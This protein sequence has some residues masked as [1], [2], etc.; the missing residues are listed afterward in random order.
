MATSVTNLSPANA[1]DIILQYENLNRKREEI[2]K[3]KEA[4]TVFLN[5]QYKTLINDIDAY[6]Y[7][8]NSLN[9][10]SGG[11]SLPSFQE[12]LR[13]LII[14]H[15]F[16]NAADR[17]IQLYRDNSSQMAHDI[18][19][20]TKAASS[21]RW[22]FTSSREKE[23][24]QAAYIRLL[25]LSEYRQQVLMTHQ[26]IGKEVSS[27]KAYELFYSNQNVYASI[28]HEL[29]MLYPDIRTNP[30][31]RIIRLHQPIIEAAMASL[32]KSEE[33]HTELTNKI[34]SHATHLATRA[35]ID[36]LQKMD[37]DLLAKVKSGVRIKALR[38]AGYTTIASVLTASSYQ[39]ASINGISAETA[40]LIKDAAKEFSDE[41]Y[42]GIRVR[43][44]AENQSPDAL[45]LV[46]DTYSYIRLTK[47][48]DRLSSYIDS[49]IKPAS[50]AVKALKPYNCIIDYIAL[51]N[52]EPVRNNY[53]VLES[54][55]S[56][57]DA[58]I[59]EFQFIP[60]SN[61][62]V[63]WDDF[64]HNP[65]D[66]NT[67]WQNIVPDLFGGSEGQYGLPEGL[68][69]EIQDQEF[70]PDGLKVTLRRYQEW[71]VKY[72]LHQGKI[73]LGDEM[74]LG[75]TVQAIATMVSLKNTGAHHFLVVC[76]ASV[77]PNWC[78]EIE[79]KSAFHPT[80]I[81]GNT[82]TLSL[83]EWI[84]TGGVA[85][86]TF[87]T[88]SQIKFAEGFHYDLLVVDEAHYIK[89]P[90]AVRSKAVTVLS[91]AASRII[92][93][94]G[95]A[96]EN[97]VDE[98]ITL[99][100]I[101][102]PTI[103]SSIQSVAYLSTAPMFR[104]LVAPVYY[105]RKREE[106]LQELP[107]KEEMDTWVDLLPEELASYKRAVMSKNQTEIRRV[108]WANNSPERSAKAQRL[109]EIVE[110]AANEGRRVL[111]F[112]FYKDTLRML[113]RFLGSLC[114]GMIDGNVPVETR[115][116]IIDKFEDS[117]VGSVLLAQIN[118]GG[119]GLNIQSAS[120]VIIC[121]PQL[122]PSIE[123]QAISRA[124]RMGQAHKV[125]VYRLLASNTIDERITDLLEK[126]RAA[127]QAFADKSA[128]AEYTNDIDLK[129]ED[130]TF[131]KLIQ[132]EIDRIKQENDV[133]GSQIVEE[134]ESS[135]PTSKSQSIEFKE[136]DLLESDMVQESNENVKWNND[137]TVVK[138]PT[139]PVIHQKPSEAALS[140]IS[141]DAFIRYM[142][143]EEIEYKDNR[144]N[145]GCLWV[146]SN[147]EIDELIRNLR[148]NGQSLQ[149]SPSA[150]ALNRKPGW[151]IS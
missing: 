143:D 33:Y 67:V 8:S 112:S 13:R 144:S 57:P 29:E 48:K 75:K 140:F 27:D 9:G 96:L 131:G 61:F 47:N 97:K 150:K 121:E 95:T 18:E 142:N 56:N 100:K 39:I 60:T 90:K 65:I 101:L 40:A 148:I 28:I 11:E 129:I 3:N 35:A 68:A 88:T 114:V 115:Q 15:D 43:I 2:E 127:F 50:N 46:S 10:K 122:K 151:Y 24:S 5:L 91:E 138:A 83:N 17:C 98:M 4:L 22:L 103:A 82:R 53:H 70:F 80:R 42:K 139:N 105:R 71:G 12:F 78:K 86:T 85:V 37:V 79:K 141:I 89:N 32:Q 41:F 136:E 93:M 62:N 137:T 25:G 59:N 111:V 99:V 1:K 119:T 26:M 30:I 94:T 132:E 76:P 109:K 38:D 21:L 92:F 133:D 6:E 104:E 81:Y 107:E 73:I 74:G 126:K 58:I 72:A 102:N 128:A 118:A 66:Y 45:L 23:K 120:V 19:M 52:P 130:K 124:Y 49:V 69:K 134:K 125:L 63:T 117:K 64:L 135:F 106:V 108:S 113:Q 14:Y 44:T 20:M 34:R 123:D 55:P 54:L 51:Q 149:Y 147:D 77:L 110:E 87:E 116:Q 16:S 31:S 146:M 36:G 7:V 84:K 145:N